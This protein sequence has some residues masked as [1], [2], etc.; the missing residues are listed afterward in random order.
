MGTRVRIRPSVVTV[1]PA[2]ALGAGRPAVRRAAAPRRA[3]GGTRRGSSPTG[4]LAGLAGRWK[5]FPCVSGA[6]CWPQG[7]AAGPLYLR[8]HSGVGSPLEAV[9]SRLSAVGEGFT[10][11]EDVS[12]RWKEF[13]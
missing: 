10:P 12:R 7:R 2:P 6:S 5:T 4:F 13:P 8:P 1:R 3:R 9:G 11:L